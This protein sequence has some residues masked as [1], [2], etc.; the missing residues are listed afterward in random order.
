MAWRIKETKEGEVLNNFSY[1][2][3]DKIVKGVNPKVLGEQFASTHFKEDTKELT[4]DEIRYLDEVTD[5]IKRLN[6]YGIK[7]SNEIKKE[8]NSIVKSISKE[9]NSFAKLERFFKEKAGF[10]HDAFIHEEE[11]TQEARVNLREE[12]DRFR[13]EHNITKREASYPKSYIL[14]FAWIF[15]FIFLE[16]LA[17]AYFFGQAS[18][19]GLLGGVFIGFITSFFNVVLSTIAGFVLRYKN[20]TVQ[21]V[22]R[23]GLAIFGVLLLLIFFIHLFIAHYREVLQTNPHVQIGAV[24]KPMFQTPF[25]LHDMESLILVA[26]GVLV[27]LFSIIKGMK[28]DDKYPGYGAVYRRWKASDNEFLEAKRQLRRL[29]RELHM[30]TIRKSD[31]MLESL[32]NSKEKLE[33]LALDLDSFIS[34]YRS[35]YNKAFQTGREILVDYRLGVESF[36]GED[37]T[38]DYKKILDNRLNKLNINMLLNIK[39]LIERELNSINEQI[40]SFYA[41]QEIF[42]HRLEEMKEKYLENEYIEKVI[43][44][45]KKNREIEL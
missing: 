40:D 16:A 12:L 10:I 28:I 7:K 37:D 19:L 27:T 39:L 30:V 21:K 24:L 33:A 18:S 1:I 45:V 35:Y 43:K 17:N 44:Q 29:M 20:H 14:H 2:E 41:N 22:R 4:N 25:V 15:V 34:T 26:I 32:E 3:R 11:T 9:E 38:F 42:E 8:V 31:K 5:Y 6:A 36:H 13:Q 23:I